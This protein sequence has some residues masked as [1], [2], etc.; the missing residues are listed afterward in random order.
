MGIY[1]FTEQ[2]FSKEPYPK[3]SIRPEEGQEI[4]NLIV[5]KIKGNWETKG[6]SLEELEH[7]M[8]HNG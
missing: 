7:K 6:L 1:S 5:N 8:L 2:I 3:L 4:K